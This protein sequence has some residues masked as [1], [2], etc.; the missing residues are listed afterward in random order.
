MDKMTGPRRVNNLCPDLFYTIYVSLPQPYVL[1]GLFLYLSYP[2]PTIFSIPQGLK[3]VQQNFANIFIL[4]LLLSGPRRGRGAVCSLGASRQGVRHCHRG[5]GRPH[6][7]LNSAASSHHIQRRSQDPH[8][9]VPPRQS[10]RR[11]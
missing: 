3:L 5:H 4:L 1:I 8:T 11:P 6:V 2:S 10:A 9:R 7:R